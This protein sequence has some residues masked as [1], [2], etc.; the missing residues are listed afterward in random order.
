MKSRI[1]YDLDLEKFDQGQKFGN[2]LLSDLWAN[3]RR[4]SLFSEIMEG[5]VTSLNHLISST[6]I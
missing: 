3:T 6:T 4:D 1:K 2:I 5:Y